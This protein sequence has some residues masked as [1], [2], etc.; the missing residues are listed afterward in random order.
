MEPV[1]IRAR[2]VTRR[3][4]AGAEFLHGIPE[5]KAGD[6]RGEEHDKNDDLGCPCE[7]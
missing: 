1:E 2:C 6:S 5:Y 3:I 4:L 7:L